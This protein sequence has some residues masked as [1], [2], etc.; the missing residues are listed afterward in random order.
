MKK[1]FIIVLAIL[2]CLAVTGVAIASSGSGVASDAQ[3]GISGNQPAKTGN[4]PAQNSDAPAQIG[5]MYGI[6]SVSKVFTAAAVMKL[7]DDGK[8]DLDMP[9]TAYIP[10]FTM[11]D[12]RYKLI[13][14]RMLLNHSSGL[15]GMT[16]SSAML[17]GDNDTWNHDNFLEFLKTQELKHDPGDR[18]IYS[19]DSFSLAEIL[20]ERVSGMSFTGFIEMEFA[21]PL[22][23]ENIK[24]PQ[25]DFDLNLLAH[26]YLGSSELKPQ[27][28]G[29]IGSGGVYATMEDLCRYA[30]IFMDSAD[31][32]VLSNESTDEMAK[33]QHKMEMLAPGTD[34]VFRYGLGWD[35][36]EQYP[37]NQLGIQALSK[38]GDT[39][40]YHTNLTVLPEHNM[41]AAVASS[42]DSGLEALIAQQILL[43]V[44]EEDGLIPPGMTFE[45]PRLN[46]NRAK[47]SDDIKANAGLYDTGMMGI[48]SVSFTDDSLILTPL[49]VRNER[50]MEFIYNTDDEFVSL[51]GESIGIYS[52][53]PGVRGVTKLRFEGK[54]LMLQSY[55]NI[56]GLGQGVEAMPFAEKIESNPV[57]QTA[58]DAWTARNGNEYL[59]AS[60]KYTS[61]QY[62]SAAIAR[63]VT[64]GRFPGYVVPGVY[65]GVG[66]SFPATKITDGYSAK[67]YQSIPTMMGRDIV[68]LSVSADGRYLDI[69][70]NRYINAN[71]AVPFSA[72]GGTVVVGSEPVWADIGGGWGG[73]I[74]SIVTPANGSWFV[75]DDK[76]NCITTSLEMYL[77]ETVLLPEN[78]RLA[79]AGEPGA[80][81][82]V[83]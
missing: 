75:Y 41:A 7:V 57:S 64:D 23:L 53:T 18:S 19:N 43:A 46:S 4:V 20:V 1:L 17:R 34:T 22:G 44:L 3:R 82:V 67:G 26:T 78:G 36:V 24:T 29:V 6:G 38:G 30:T 72:L 56:P 47:V 28:L 37:F 25:S 73:K 40:A 5:K 45:L 63:T 83:S 31:G 11:A 48:Y 62:I 42:G 9:V 68:N 32:S 59:L 66:K 27:H 13:T 49:G 55:E 2:I 69:N 74:V 80:V 52:L 10:E 8:I 15:M 33:N 81:F 71:T 39:S 76:M 51:N 58:Q 35:C 70:N 16:G 21:A 50:P 61:E 54:Y 14:P 77:R 12:D 65:K 79:F 60:E